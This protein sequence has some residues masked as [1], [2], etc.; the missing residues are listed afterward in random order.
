[1]LKRLLHGLEK[2]KKEAVN[3]ERIQPFYLQLLKR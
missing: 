2:V 3:P 1:M